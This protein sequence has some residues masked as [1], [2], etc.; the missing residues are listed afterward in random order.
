M[1]LKEAIPV[2]FGIVCAKDASVAAYLEFH[3][4]SNQWNVSFDRAAYDW[5][6]DVFASF[7]RVFYSAIV[8]RES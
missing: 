8:R 4:G 3:G 7:S 1:A 2:L 6:V 5:V